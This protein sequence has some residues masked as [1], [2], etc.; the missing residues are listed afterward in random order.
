[1]NWHTNT[2]L[3]FRRRARLNFIFLTIGVLFFLILWI[4]LDLKIGRRF[5]LSN[6]HRNP[7]PI[8][9]SDLTLYTDG[10]MFYQSLSSALEE[11]Q[12]SIHIMFFIWRTDEIGVNFIEQLCRKAQSGVEVKLLVDR[13]G[14][15]GFLA[16][17]KQT[18]S[19]SNI[20]FAYSHRCRFPF[21]F[22]TLNQRN[23]RKMVIIDGKIA[24]LGGF[25][26]GKEY[27]G[28]GKLGAWR[29][30]HIQFTGEGAWE[31]E[32]RFITDWNTNVPLANQVKPVSNTPIKGKSP[33]EIICTEAA[34]L[35]HT[36]LDLIVHAKKEIYIGTPYFIPGLKIFR[37][38]RQAQKRGAALTI[39]IPTREDHLLVKDAAMPYLRRLHKYGAKIYLYQGGFFHGKLVIVDQ[40]L[41]FIGTA[42]FDLRSMYINHEMSCLIHDNH[43]TQEVLRTFQNDL[44]HSKL[45][46]STDLASPYGWKRCKEWLAIA[47]SPFL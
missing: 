27:V 43:F 18:L 28:A 30:Y 7:S 24:Y 9:Y 47:L 15:R 40:K 11:S 3:D 12:I 20:Q 41:C 37:A 1:M 5:Y 10:A 23:H 34:Y 36:F 29:D 31:I 21:I 44:D 4:V 25:N 46:I 19:E 39:L 38:L 26:I 42:N 22:F 17:F 35:F 13:L 45:A 32:K 14:S 33:H 2:Y 8:C 6:K 16:H